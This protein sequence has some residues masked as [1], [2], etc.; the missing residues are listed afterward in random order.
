MTNRTMR[1][2][3]L[4]APSVG[5]TSPRTGKTASSARPAR[6]DHLTE[7]AGDTTTG[8]GAVRRQEYNVT[9]DGVTWRLEPVNASTPAE[10]R[11]SPEATPAAFRQ[12]HVAVERNMDSANEVA[13]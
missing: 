3:E 13:R 9:G 12:L 1:S 8:D 6:A 4:T 7:A 2:N 11:R 5:L 10:T